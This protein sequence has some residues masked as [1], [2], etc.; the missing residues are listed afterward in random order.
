MLSDALGGS[1]LS[2]AVQDGA[3]AAGVQPWR[4]RSAADWAAHAARVRASADR[5]WVSQ[6]GPAFQAVGPAAE[7]LDRAARDGI[8]VTTGQQAG[9]FGGPLY[10]LS[11]AISALALADRLQETLGMPVAP[12]FWAATDDADFL[13]AATVHVADT[14][15]VHRLS[16]E[17]APPAGTPMARAPLGDTTA[18]LRQ[19]HAACGSAAHARFLEMARTA[20]SG[21]HTMGSAYVELLRDLLYPLG[22]AVLDSSHAVVRGAGM[23]TLGRAMSRAAEVHDAL[24][25]RARVLREAGFEP[26]VDD[27]RGLS[28]VFAHE[29]G[30]KRRLSVAEAAA[31]DPSPELVVSPNVLLRP[32]VERAILPTAAYVAGPG[33]LAYFA[34]VAAVADAIGAAVPVALPRWSATVIEPHTARALSRLGITPADASDAHAL[35]ARFARVTMPKAV[36]ESWARLAQQVAASVDELDAAVRETALVPAPVIEGLRRGLAHKLA[37]AERRLLAAAKRRDDGV[38]R[39]IATVTSSLYP[40]GKRQERALSF[41]PMLARGGDE[42]LA[43]M[44]AEARRHAESLVPSARTEPAATR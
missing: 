28:L 19:L 13:E 24:V 38:R 43:A 26:Q 40:L 31:L 44:R 41:I 14:G 23:P 34:Q 20:F 29:R 36:A 4:P 12:V 39:D 15:G 8:V 33:E 32:V 17:H 27:D 5:D 11:K 2:R 1:P 16:L 37:R 21:S 35:E 7:R 42:L 3:L 22:I 25:E 10:T 9:L 30:L 6:L 18:L